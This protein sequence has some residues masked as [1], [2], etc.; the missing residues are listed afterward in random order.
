MSEIILQATELRKTFDDGDKPLEVLA[1][2][3]FSVKRGET[4]AIVGASGSGKSTLLHCLGGLEA[5]S[6]GRVELS[7]VNFASLDERQRGLLRNQSLGFVYQYHHLLPEFTAL[8]NV[9][10]P[11]L[12][13][14]KANKA[15]RQRAEELLT[16]VGLQHRLNHKPPALSGGERQRTAIARSLITRPKCILCDE[17]TGNLDRDSA[18]RALELLLELNAELKTSLVIATHDEAIAGKLSKCYRMHGDGKIQE[19]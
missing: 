10:M 16:K 13:R 3:N 2:I 11:M 15:A 14:G 17:P 18:G 4:V 9:L 7:G 19:L 6:A 5:V 12:I 1:G 8:E